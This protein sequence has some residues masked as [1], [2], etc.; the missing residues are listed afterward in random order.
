MWFTD[1][2]R[3]LLGDD[4]PPDELNHAPRKGLA[5]G[6][7]YCHAG[8]VKDPEFGEKHACSEFQ[9]PARKLDPHGAAIGM[10][11]YRGRIPGGVSQSDFHCPARLAT[12]WPGSFIES[13]IKSSGWRLAIASWRL[14]ADSGGSL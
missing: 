12:I 3:D 11:F 13:V 2:G 6:F 5:F 14:G 8:E 1:T 7:P 4:I 9:A 10:R